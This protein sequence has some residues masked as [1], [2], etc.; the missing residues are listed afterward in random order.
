M[1]K[2]DINVNH[3]IEVYNDDV[4]QREGQLMA[5]K[6]FDYICD[7]SQ[8]TN[9]FLELG[10]GDGD[11]IELIDSK[12]SNFIVL[13]AE[14]KLID[15]YSKTYS[16]ITFFHTYFEDFKTTEKFDNIG[17]GFIID[18]VKNPVQLLIKYAD[19]LTKDGLIYLSIGNA[20]SLHRRIAHHAG[21]IDDLK[22]MSDYNKSIN[23]QTQYTFDEL[24]IIF[25]EARLNI[26]A[27]HGLFLKSFSTPQIDSL[28]L[29]DN[30]YNALAETA[31]DLP[32]ISNACFFVLRK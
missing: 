5:R 28:K 3:N 19:L 7:Y 8:S 16:D 29:D 9:N 15:Q 12:F 22:R 26:V 25:K 17:M 2:K 23:H 14:Q 18:I 21:L 11:A 6:Y 4:Y 31:K 1:A 24:I 10:I 27:T 20:S 30:I 32:E 13:D